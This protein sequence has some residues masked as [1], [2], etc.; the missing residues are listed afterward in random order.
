MT[1]T[2]TFDIHSPTTGGLVGS[3]PVLGVDA[4]EEVVAHARG[5]GRWWAGLGFRERSRR[6]R[7]WA[8][9]IAAHEIELAQLIALETGKPLPDAVLE[10]ALTLDHLAWAG[11]NASR[12]LGKRRVSRTIL[13]ANQSASLRYEP[14]GV[15][16]VIGPW[17]Y[18][19]FTPMGSIAYALAAGNAV[20]FKPSEFTTA[21]GA[22][23]VESF[24]RVV[25]E[26]P[27]LQQVSGRGGT[28]AALCRSGVDKV[29]FTGSTTTGARV[30]ATCAESLTPVVLELGGKDALIVDVDADVSAAADAAAFGGVSN[31]GQSCTAVE[32]VFVV[33]ERYDQFVAELSA[34]LRN[35]TPG[36][37]D[38]ASYGPMTMPSQVEVVRR[39]VDAA[40][41]DGG[42]AVV[43]GPE[44]VGDRL[45]GPILL[46]DVPPGNIAATEETF[47]PTIV[48]TKVRDLDQ[49]I[50]LANST[51]FGLAASVFGK[52]R[53]QEAAERLRV[54]MVSINSWVMYAG[55][56]ALSWGGVG[57]S[58]FGRIHGADGLR[59]FARS[60]AI[61]RQQFKAPI[62]LTSFSRAKR[63]TDI[64]VRYDRLRH[65]R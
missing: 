20:V 10:V 43:G 59:E 1:V 30:M 16:G 42:R 65:R 36:S 25:P 12:V 48:V 2:E 7:R 14:F 34:I 32:R 8:A 37:Q 58:G 26:H 24:A 33:A 57:S 19:V 6:L 39:H 55:V 41:A 27:V 63:A 15:V 31:A 62:S 61:T 53:A 60:K 3:F 21:T 64:V 35:L 50:E 29:S 47:G 22:W 56:P 45:I 11:R 52:R 49:A 46:T 23:L 13:T 4:V 54:G 18:P 40:L 51:P 9:D 38:G 28:G 17:N 5:A 44:S